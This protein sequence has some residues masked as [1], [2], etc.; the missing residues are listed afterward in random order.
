MF[1]LWSV[2]T[3]VIFLC[4]KLMTS[5]HIWTRRKCPYDYQW[6]YCFKESIPS[7]PYCNNHMTHHEF[8]TM[9]VHIPRNPYLLD[10]WIFWT[11]AY[12]LSHMSHESYKSQ[13]VIWLTRVLLSPLVSMLPT[14]LCE[15]L[16]FDEKRRRN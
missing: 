14:H 16:V 10:I 2:G 4:M 13:W 9:C 8:I 7:W 1:I 11:F 3:K 6:Q 5:C 15:Y 12:I